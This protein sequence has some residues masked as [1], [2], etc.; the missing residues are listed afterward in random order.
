MIIVSP[1]KILAILLCAT[2]LWNE[3]VQAAGFPPTNVTPVGTHCTTFQQEALVNSEL[4]SRLSFTP[5]SAAAAISL[6]AIGVGLI[7]HVAGA[8]LLAATTFV[9]RDSLSVPLYV[10]KLS[11]EI[12]D[13]LKTRIDD[14]RETHI[15]R[16]VDFERDIIETRGLHNH[17]VRGEDG[18]WWIHLHLA[19]PGPDGD[20][21]VSPGKQSLYNGLLFRMDLDAPTIQLSHPLGELES[22]SHFVPIQAEALGGDRYDWLM[23]KAL[24]TVAS[25]EPE[26]RRLV[27]EYP[28]KVGIRTLVQAYH[29]GQPLDLFGLTLLWYRTGQLSV[30][31]SPIQH[32]LEYRPQLHL[33][34]VVVA[35]FAGIL[36]GVSSLWHPAHILQAGVVIGLAKLMAPQGLSRRNFLAAMLATAGALGLR[37]EP[38]PITDLRELMA[39][40]VDPPAHKSA[41]VALASLA[42][43]TPA[44]RVTFVN[45][46]LEM[47]LRAQARDDVQA[48]ALI[49]DALN[50]LEDEASLR[51]VMSKAKRTSL[52]HALLPRAVHYPNLFDLIL[53]YH[54]FVAKDSL[55]D[56]E[57][58]PYI[59]AIL[60]GRNMYPEQESGLMEN[61]LRLRQMLEATAQSRDDVVA[62][63]RERIARK[64]GLD[65]LLQ[66]WE[67]GVDHLTESD[68]LGLLAGLDRDVLRQLWVERSGFQDRLKDAYLVPIAHSDSEKIVRA[69][70]PNPDEVFEMWQQLNRPWSQWQEAYRRFGPVMEA[71]LTG[72]EL[73]PVP[74]GSTRDSSTASERTARELAY[75]SLD[76]SGLYDLLE[77][78]RNAPKNFPLS[79]LIKLI[80]RALN[81][82]VTLKNPIYSLLYIQ[83][84][85]NP[86]TQEA[87]AE[88]LT[89][90]RLDT[91]GIEG[92]LLNAILAFPRNTPLPDRNRGTQELKILSD[93][94]QKNQ[95]IAEG[96]PEQVSQQVSA[97]PANPNMALQVIT[98]LRKIGPPS[99][100]VDANH[101]DVTLE[102]RGSGD[103]AP[104]FSKQ[105]RSLPAA[106]TSRPQ[107]LRSVLL[108][109]YSNDTVLLGLLVNSTDRAAAL[110]Q[111]AQG[112]NDL[113]EAF[114]Q[115][116]SALDI[117]ISELGSG[118]DQ[119]ADKIIRRIGD[120]DLRRTFLE[121]LLIDRP[122]L[123]ARYGDSEDLTNILQRGEDLRARAPVIRQL[124]QQPDLAS[125]QLEWRARIFVVQALENT[126][127]APAASKIIAAL[128]IPTGDKTASVSRRRWA[129]IAAGLTIVGA[130]GLLSGGQIHL[131]Q[132]GVAGIGL[133]SWSRR[134]ALKAM[135]ATAAAGTSWVKAQSPVSPQ[136]ENVQLEETLPGMVKS[137]GGKSIDDLETAKGVADLLKSLLEWKLSGS[138]TLPDAV[139]APL[140]A[141][142][143]N[144]MVLSTREDMTGQPNVKL[145]YRN[146][147]DGH[148]VDTTIF[149]RPDDVKSKDD[150]IINPDTDHRF[151]IYGIEKSP[152]SFLLLTPEHLYIFEKKIKILQPKKKLPIQE[153]YFDITILPNGQQGKNGQA[154]LAGTPGRLAGIAWLTSLGKTWRSFIDARA[155]EAEWRAFVK[156][157][158]DD[159][160]EFEQ[161]LARESLRGSY[162]DHIFRQAEFENERIV[163]WLDKQA[164]KHD[165]NWFY[166]VF[167]QT[168]FAR[169]HTPVEH[170][171][172]IANLNRGARYRFLE[173]QLDFGSDFIPWVAGTKCRLSR[174]PN[175]QQISLEVKNPPDAPGDSF[176]PAVIHADDMDWVRVP[177]SE[178]AQPDNPHILKSTYL[179]SEVYLERLID[180]LPSD[181]SAAKIAYKEQ[182]R[183]W[184]DAYGYHG[185][186][187]LTELLHNGEMDVIPSY[188]TRALKILPRFQEEARNLLIPHENVILAASPSVFFRSLLSRTTIMLGIFSILILI[189]LSGSY[190]AP[191]A[192]TLAVTLPLL[193]RSLR[194]LSIEPH[195]WLTTMIDNVIQ[196]DR[197]VDGLN[198]EN[199]QPHMSHLGRF[200]KEERTY[201]K[202]LEQ[203]LTDDGQAWPVIF[204]KAEDRLF[205]S[206]HHDVDLTMMSIPLV[207]TNKIGDAYGLEGF[208]DVFKARLHAILTEELGQT[209]GLIGGRLLLLHVDPNRDAGILYKAVHLARERTKQDPELQA[210]IQARFKSEADHKRAEFERAVDHLSFFV[211]HRYIDA[212]DIVNHHD[213]AQAS[214]LIEVTL[215]SAFKSL[216]GRLEALEKNPND[217]LRQFVE[218]HL[219]KTPAGRRPASDPPILMFPDAATHQLVKELGKRDPALRIE[220]DALI[221]QGRTKAIP[222]FGY[223]SAK[224]PR[225]AHNDVN[226]ILGK[227]SDLMEAFH[228]L[229]EDPT[230][231][232]R[233]NEFKQSYAEYRAVFWRSL[234]GAY[235]DPRLPEI[236]KLDRIDEWVEADRT[237]ALERLSAHLQ[238]PPS[239][240]SSTEEMGDLVDLFTPSNVYMFKRTVGDEF[241]VVVKAKGHY[242]EG[243]AELNKGNAYFT[244]YG[245]DTQDSI[246]HGILLELLK[247]AQ[248][249]R[250][251][252]TQNP[253]PLGFLALW[254]EAI[255]RVAPQEFTPSEKVP[256]DHGTERMAAFQF[257]SEPNP[258]FPPVVRDRQGQFYIRDSD[259]PTGWSRAASIDP[260][261][262]EPFETHLT[263]ARMYDPTAVRPGQFKA[264]FER[265]SQLISTQKEPERGL[266]HQVVNSQTLK[267][268]PLVR[269][270]TRALP[271]LIAIIVSG[272]ALV[273]A[274]HPANHHLELSAA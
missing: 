232:D 119:A 202:E 196:R 148:T 144:S 174:V 143:L 258:D 219:R 244:R 163:W 255:Q 21:S 101:L 224:L 39:T 84:L 221:R 79:T 26:I 187:R 186:N 236:F 256:T 209:A 77:L 167:D 204:E 129:F 16:A 159:Y 12:H 189:I 153:T 161:G 59:L 136:V 46:L 45:E 195:E 29:E 133:M 62:A 263:A 90:G 261:A 125:V 241:G 80:N 37:S 177:G 147:I 53:D 25:A 1:R 10:L 112:E 246:Y 142:V 126:E 64:E 27:K 198:A 5:K 68:V 70:A 91:A 171:Q 245:T 182:C 76:G 212:G 223:H 213:R 179:L 260:N 242:W 49:D 110:E 181:E 273:S 2:L 8:A 175:V 184:L 135:L 251:K 200:V 149:V 145:V 41:I 141:K 207:D 6:I 106:T 55:W 57:I 11:Q 54:H 227:G 205:N 234:A 252:I 239:I 160:Q 155:I 231:G 61:L 211:S 131:V 176:L 228:R 117:I 35:A 247:T 190:A 82:D 158:Y 238:G 36:M 99:S 92:P 23:K 75:S 206:D 217:K 268:D 51:E 103:A 180:N 146:T 164:E 63:L 118:M 226:W 264:T 225:I 194:S 113:S 20:M 183:L 230:S 188:R 215:E 85:A 95:T 168:L 250:S 93:V 9:G 73:P 42:D 150:L 44:Y 58:R 115:H 197:W 89:L 152:S 140:K 216:N 222:L 18:S 88:K 262:L 97:D 249:H 259:S 120:E 98:S 32:M 50:A 122:S 13:Q 38:A 128:K 67:N 96:G 30:G 65:A 52:W 71:V 94:A 154:P 201:L 66:I 24:Q 162:H 34:L 86:A 248:D 237:G 220:F 138:P 109:M 266:I 243:F 19:Q 139:Q 127:L 56:P 240:F 14:L 192:M 116:P 104:T 210:T 203:R 69:A 102:V 173:P 40:V 156:K 22:F 172:L 214:R 151:G 105:I 78:W 130:I 218:Q 157:S 48:I 170:R 60:S 269:L 254:D 74:D 267:A 121:R 257:R 7:H 33:P 165:L 3:T 270:L 137:N 199:I 233:L 229:Q 166:A 111:L 272:L 208:T 123:F 83:A 43:N 178:K 253:S 31:N 235:R 114:L 15:W 124:A 274:V 47:R 87:A 193:R 132:A 4:F 185:L 265:L 81:S 17:L 108:N 134:Q 100:G 271:L 72:R 107:N 169:K 28:K 191:G